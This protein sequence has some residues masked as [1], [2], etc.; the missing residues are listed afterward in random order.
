MLLVISD[1][2]LD[3]ISKYPIYLFLLDILI[4]KKDDIHKLIIH[5]LVLDLLII[6]SSFI[7]GSIFIIYKK[8][9]IKKINMIN[10]ILSISL[11]FG[12]FISILGIVNHYSLSFIFELGLKYYLI[13]LPI[14]IL[15]YK[16]LEKRIKLARWLNGC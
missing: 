13:N 8:L 6:N 16:I 5:S 4:L 11:I 10:Y 9:P 1:I 3:I 12:I 14:Y 15:S 7:M 2:I